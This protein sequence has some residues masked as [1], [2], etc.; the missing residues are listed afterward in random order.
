M[1]R[2][3]KSVSTSSRHLTKDE[4]TVRQE[5]E[6]M[7]RGGGGKLVPPDWLSVRQVKLFEFVKAELKESGILGNL[8]I[9]VL[10]QFAVAVD[11]LWTI[12]GMI[13]Q[14]P[15]L[16]TDKDML[17]A[18]DKYTKDLY[19]CCNELSL[20]PQARAKIGTLNTAQKT[21]K[22]DP[23][24]IALEGKKGKVSSA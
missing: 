7:L 4:K 15:G 24:L 17:S 23:V 16:V 5:A 3:A 12:E 13:N 11:R 19:R 1:G 8:D 10:S 6:A 20:S 18:K 14:E 22:T 21:Q 9:F 2:P